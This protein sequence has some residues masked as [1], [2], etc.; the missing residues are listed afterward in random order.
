M[1]AASEITRLPSNERLNITTL[2]PGTAD[3]C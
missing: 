1:A 2:P 3:A